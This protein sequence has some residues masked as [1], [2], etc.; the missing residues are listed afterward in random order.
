MENEKMA[1]R[2]ILVDSA[3]R[4]L[5]AHGTET[6]PMTV[7]H[8]DLW[9]FEGKHVPIHWHNDLEINLLRE[10]EA[11]FQVYQKNY[12]VRPGEG[13]LLNRNVPHSCSSLGNAHVRY[14]TILVRPDFLYGDF[15]SDVERNCFRPFLQ[16][17]AVPCI[18]LTGA[19]GKETEI[20]Q[21]LNQ[22]EEAFDQKAF[23]YELKIK[24]LLCEAFGMLLYEHRQ[25]LTKFVPANQLELERLEIMLN[26]LNTHFAEVISLQELADQ[27][28]LSK[29]VCCRLFK[30]MTGKT[31]TRYLEEYRANKSL[32]LVQSG[33]Y[34]M[35]Q[36]AEIV[37]FSNPSRFASAFCR[38]FGCNPGKLSRKL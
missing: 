7:N 28:H 6:F 22:V 37:G 9:S 34:S 35:T 3:R 24:G 13:F 29:E 1:K 18:H 31:I 19:E 5:E 8:D 33:Q 26:Y 17:S 36:I 11:F 27:I 10:G 30:K 21:K 2:K 25:E 20:I 14:S 15:G 23:C 16:N 4:E 32:H 38:R 12:R